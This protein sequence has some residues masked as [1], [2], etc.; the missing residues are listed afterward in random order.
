MPRAYVKVWV[1]PGREREVCESL[2]GH[3]AVMTADVT[4]GEQDILCLIEA[5]SYEE[6]LQLVAGKLRMT[7]GITRTVTN[8]IVEQ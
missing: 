8:L 1:T 4:T 7:E 2:L 3:D 5:R 6:L